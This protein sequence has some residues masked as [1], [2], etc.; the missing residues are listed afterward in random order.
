M[1]KIDQIIQIHSIDGAA[2]IKQLIN[3]WSNS[4]T[5]Q[6]HKELSELAKLKSPVPI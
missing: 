3:S 5:I 1:N 4:E 6:F 2:Q